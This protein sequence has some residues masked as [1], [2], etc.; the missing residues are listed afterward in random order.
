MTWVLIWVMM[1]GDK[2][3][4]GS[5][6]FNSQQACEYGAKQLKSAGVIRLGWSDSIKCVPKG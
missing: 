6:E 4:S 2:I 5:Q 3:T 1:N